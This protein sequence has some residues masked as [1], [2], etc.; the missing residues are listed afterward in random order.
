M[1]GAQCLTLWSLAQV[2]SSAAPF[3]SPFTPAA[4]EGATA[5]VT[6]A[7]TVAAPAVAAPAVAAPAVA[8]PAVASA[9]AVLIVEDS[10]ILL[11]MT[12]EG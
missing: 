8:A 3:L 4:G 6:A 11:E 10:P 12:R 7:P 2:A 5:A 1:A 9:P